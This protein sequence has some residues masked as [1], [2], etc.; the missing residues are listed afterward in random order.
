M[1]PPAAATT[2]LGARLLAAAGEWLRRHA[3]VVGAVQWAIVAAYAFF[4]V[5]P[6]F[7]P[8]PA[9]DARWYNSL[10]VLSQWLFW[11]VWW[12]FV[13]LSM[14]VVGRAWCGLFCPEGTLTEAASR[15]GLGL[16]VPRWLKWG[17]W[18]FVAFALTTV[19][20]QLVSVYQYPAATMLVLG[21]STLAA[22]GVGFVYGRGKRVWCRHLCPVNGVFAVLSRVAPVHFR[23]DTEAW[24]ANIPRIRVHPVNCAPLVRIRR[25]TGPSE[26]H[27]C[28]RCSG[29]HGAIALAARSPNR[30]VATLDPNAANGWDAALIVFGM[31]GLALGAFEWSATTAFVSLRSAAIGLIVDHGPAW[32]LADNAPWWLLTNY[33]EAHDVFTW[34]DGA[35]IVVWI[36]GTALLVGGWVSA[37]LV[38]AARA[39]AGSSRANAYALAYTLIPLA[40]AG[41]FVGLSALPATLAHGEGLR[42]AW[43]PHV[44]AIL[45]AASACWSL[46]LA[47]RQLEG[48]LAGAT[49][50]GA[51]VAMAFAIGG[52]L[53]AWA[54]FV[55]H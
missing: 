48:R 34:L 36:V 11:G 38:V 6:A 40:G 24:T 46:Y 28:G 33:P 32:L 54:P 14:L 15:H 16:A 4:V 35:L 18:P 12:P 47:Y 20:G 5:V 13:I 29:L 3:R 52:V 9:D 1:S 7:L 55:Y 27:M 37:W 31:I 10:A 49:R 44:R 30:E 51:L 50:A 21:G 26:C 17:G 19:F 53:A 2:T 43:L 41:L 39:L 42:L 45:L 25:M 22:I 8:L 23:V